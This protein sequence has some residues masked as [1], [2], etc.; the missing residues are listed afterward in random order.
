MENRQAQFILRGF[1]QVAGFR[2][3]TFE[4]VTPGQPRS[5][6]TVRAD[7]AMARRYRIPLQELPMLCRTV[8]EQI[9][10]GEDRRAFVF[11]EAGMRLHADAVMERTEAARLRKS[12]RRAS[13]D[14]LGAGWRNPQ[15]R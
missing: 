1:C 6:V 4:R 5:L 8:L 15:R 12:P 9:N 7:L 3:F 14:N 11:T 2:V 13:T 10:G